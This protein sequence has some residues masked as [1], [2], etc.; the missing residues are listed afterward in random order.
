MINWKKVGEHTPTN[1]NKL[2]P[3]SAETPYVS[4]LVWICHPDV[5]HGGIA[6]I[7]RWDTENKCWL[8]TDTVRNIWL[9]DGVHKITHF[10]DDIN[11]P[12]SI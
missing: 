1:V 7:I 12:Q 3:G 4:C 5:I 9:G 2:Y 6:D 10:C 11:A 8:G